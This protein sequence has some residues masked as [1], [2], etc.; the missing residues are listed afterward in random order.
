MDELPT[1]IKA[2]LREARRAYEPPAGAR[3]HI[4]V[5]LAAAVSR[6]GL[7]LEQ[8]DALPSARETWFKL[9][10]TTVLLTVLGTSRLWLPPEV[11]PESQSPGSARALPAPTPEQKAAPLSVAEVVEADS[12][13][14]T[15]PPVTIE[16][17]EPESE[18]KPRRH[19]AS[20]PPDGTLV[21]EL[22][23]LK[24][25]SDA[26]LVH[27]FARADAL[28]ELYRTRFANGQLLAEHDGLVLVRSCLAGAPGASARAR[29]YLQAM[30]HGVLS[31][32][33]ENAC[34]GPQ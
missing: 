26:L 17:K 10:L 16:M 15:A 30:P 24:Q 11:P 33:I 12:D 2:L 34:S 31:A 1:N 21:P 23:I 25:A 3:E 5:R 20:N 13:A 18:R 7:R 9:G 8:H 22:N 14:P 19:R 4:Q 32:R 27:D 29:A 28:L 6:D